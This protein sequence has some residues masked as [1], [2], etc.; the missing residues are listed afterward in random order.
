MAA[1]AKDPYRMGVCEVEG[2]LVG[3]VGG[4]RREGV[5]MVTLPGVGLAPRDRGWAQE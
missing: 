3:N 4:N 1:R 5:Q 2:G